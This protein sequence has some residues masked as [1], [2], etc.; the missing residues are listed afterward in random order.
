M[1]GYKWI[2]TDIY[3][4]WGSVIQYRFGPWNGLS[5]SG[6]PREMPNP[7]YTYEFVVNQKEVYFKWELINSS[8]RSR[9]YLSPQGH[10]A[11]LNWV[12]PI[13]AWIQYAAI[14]VDMCAQYGQCGPNGIC[15]INKSPICSCI[16]GFEPLHPEEW[17]IANWSTKKAFRLYE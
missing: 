15:D 16:D 1:D 4:P 2:P 11:R 7:F 8:F 5:F 17:N 13:Q 14:T 9:A 12:D 6:F 10:Q 3:K